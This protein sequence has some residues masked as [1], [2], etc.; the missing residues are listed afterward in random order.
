MQVAD[1]AES[2]IVEA[3]KSL[4]GIRLVNVSDRTFLA[5]LGGKI[6]VQPTLPIKTG[7]ICP[8][9]IRRELPASAQPFMKIL[10][11]RTH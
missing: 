2:T 10:R 6:S 4:D 1:T 11:K 3:I 9:C 7:M 8:S 5:H